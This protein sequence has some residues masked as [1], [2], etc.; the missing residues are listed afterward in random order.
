MFNFKSVSKNE[1]KNVNKKKTIIFVNDSGELYYMDSKYNLYKLENAKIINDNVLK[2]M[3]FPNYIF[4]VERDES[5]CEL[6]VYDDYTHTHSKLTK[7]IDIIRV[8]E[9]RNVTL[10]STL[11]DKETS[12]IAP[13]SI[14]NNI[15]TMDSKRSLQNI[16]DD[17]LSKHIGKYESAIRYIEV[18][19]PTIRVYEIPAPIPNLTIKETS[20]FLMFIGDQQIPET[21]YK[22]LDNDYQI[23]FNEHVELTMGLRIMCLFCYHRAV[24]LSNLKIAHGNLNDEMGIEWEN[25]QR[26]LLNF[27]NPHRT[28]KSHVGLGNVQ[29]YPVATHSEAE[30][31]ESDERYMTPLKTK[32]LIRDLIAEG[33]IEYSSYLIKRTTWTYRYLS[34]S[35]RSYNIP[36][37]YYDPDMDNLTIFMYGL[38]LEKGT[39]YTI[40]GRTVRL[41]IEIELEAPLEHIIEKVVPNDQER[42]PVLTLKNT[43]KWTSSNGSQDT[44]ALPPNMYTS[45]CRI[46]L[47]LEG[48][49]MVENEHYTLSDNIVKISEPVDVGQSIYV[50]IYETNF[51]WSDVRNRPNPVDNLNSDSHIDYLTARQ[52]K[53]LS[54]KI[55]RSLNEFRISGN[56][57]IVTENDNLTITEIYNGDRLLVRE[58]IENSDNVK[59]IRTFFMDKKRSIENI[60][61]RITKNDNVTIKD[62]L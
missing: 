29:N 24:D 59:N 55:G 28:H 54:Q 62:Y 30:A 51:N 1:L 43:F 17:P 26:H 60:N 16:L 48:V 61:I 31:G 5:S 33:Y 25:S 49:K 10:I 46:D 15:M 37:T 58:E 40:S 18:I 34:S 13:I 56:R 21:H 42:V 7:T 32:L 2:N 27:N 3:V 50:T 14:T 45:S 22:V 53:V 35:I 41:L 4:I 38:C 12:G 47:F 11:S 20:L 19:N 36:S 9:S 8:I 39:D 52:G 57:E 6:Y 44:F 23:E